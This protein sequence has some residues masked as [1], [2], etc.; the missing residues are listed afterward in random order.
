M[1]L[2]GRDKPFNINT[3]RGL[4]LIVALIY[5]TKRPLRGF[6]TNRAISLRRLRGEFSNSYSKT[7]QK[8]G[9]A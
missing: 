5:Q 1:Q 3:N 7:Y 6:D 8:T 2:S 4:G 9:A